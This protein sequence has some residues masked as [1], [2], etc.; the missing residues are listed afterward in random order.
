MRRPTI[1]Y[2]ENGLPV[3][4]LSRR[5]FLLPD[6]DEKYVRQC[7]HDMD[8]ETLNTLLRTRA[9]EDV[10]ATFPYPNTVDSLCVGSVAQP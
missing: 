6:A 5:D 8:V 2:M 9:L 7:F 1:A 4:L 3:Q 10:V